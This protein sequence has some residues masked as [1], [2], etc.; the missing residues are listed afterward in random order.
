MFERR[1]KMKEKGTMV[2]GTKGGSRKMHYATIEGKVYTST[3]VDTNKVKQIKEDSMCSINDSGYCYS[4]K[5]LDGQEGID[6]LEQYRSK[7]G[8]MNKMINIF[9]GSKTPVVIELSKV[10]A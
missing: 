9:I 6:M 8:F 10:E 4:A 2:L 7:M 5:V 3:G 1:D